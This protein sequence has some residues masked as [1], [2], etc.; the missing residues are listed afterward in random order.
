MSTDG[1]GLRAIIISII[2]CRP[3]LAFY[4]KRLKLLTSEMS[5]RYPDCFQFILFRTKYIPRNSRINF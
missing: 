2:D 3:L 5:A 1:G 4:V